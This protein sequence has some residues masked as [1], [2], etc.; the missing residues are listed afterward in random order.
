M[1]GSEGSEG[2][3]RKL[4]VEMMQNGCK[5]NAERFLYVDEPFYVNLF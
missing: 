3:F 2:S 5:K 1:F 4:F